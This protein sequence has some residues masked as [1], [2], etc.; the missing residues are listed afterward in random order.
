MKYLRALSIL[1]LA[2]L[3]TVPLTSAEKV[4]NVAQSQILIQNDNYSLPYIVK[5]NGSSSNPYLIENIT[6]HVSGLPA[7][8]IENSHKHLVI[9]N[10]TVYST[11]AFYAIEIKNSSNVTL[12]G[13]KVLRSDNF[14]LGIINSTGLRIF[15]LSL[16]NCPLPIYFGKISDRNNC[17]RGVYIDGIKAAFYRNS[18]NLWINGTYSYVSIYNCSEVNLDVKVVSSYV[19]I[20]LAYSEGVSMK[21]NVTAD[22]YGVRIFYSHDVEIFDSSFSRTG[23]NTILVQ[24]SSEIRI[25]NVTAG[26]A[27]QGFLS[28]SKSSD[29]FLSKVYTPG[30]LGQL[31]SCS[32]ALI[33]SSSGSSGFG[34][35]K[36]YNVTLRKLYFEYQNHNV[37]E[38]ED[39]SKI[40]VIGSHFIGIRYMMGKFKQKPVNAIEAISSFDLKFS[41]DTFYNDWTGIFFLGCQNVTILESYFSDCTQGI[42]VKEWWIPNQNY[43]IKDC[44]F[45]SNTVAAIAIYSGKD[46]YIVHNLFKNNEGWALAL[47][48]SGFSEVY[49]NTFT[50]NSKDVDEWCHHLYYNPELK[51]G[52]YWDRYHGPDNNHDGIGDVPYLVSNYSQD[53]YPLMKPTFTTVYTPPLPKQGLSYVDKFFIFVG[54]VAAASIILH[55]THFRKK[56]REGEE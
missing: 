45:I 39:S 14:G 17:F 56:K 49:L 7:I 11:G 40:S 30:S 23:Y 36:C 50:G 24:R 41:Q 35:S 10:V 22:N 3:L 37:L 51:K 34:I 28:A 6:L 2:F 27:F 38:I 8:L 55:Y 13:V 16:K 18:K 54:A 26:E 53:K 44:E 42:M 4:Q 20:D 5:G 29:I 31:T 19:G 12:M 46:F 1:L 25:Y 9:K 43:T 48:T 32:N 47:M 52:N 33:E 21:V 15:N